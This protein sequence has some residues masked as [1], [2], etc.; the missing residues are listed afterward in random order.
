MPFEIIQSP[1]QQKTACAEENFNQYAH[2]NRSV[3]RQELRYDDG[4]K[5][6]SKP[7]VVKCLIEMNL[8]RKATPEE[9]ANIAF[10]MQNPEQ[11]GLQE[12]IPVGLVQQIG[13][14]LD[15]AHPSIPQRLLDEVTESGGTVKIYLD[16]TTFY[17]IVAEYPEVVVT[18]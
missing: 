1:A 15:V 3:T 9:F 14:P 4:R 8:S 11:F 12:L 5:I 2:R 6:E 17:D 16:G 18:E 7:G 13:T 10:A